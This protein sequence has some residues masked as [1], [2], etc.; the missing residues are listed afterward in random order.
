MPTS[1]HFQHCAEFEKYLAATGVVK[2]PDDYVWW[3]N[4]ISKWLGRRIGPSELSEEKDVQRLLAEVRALDATSPS[5]RL[6]TNAGSANN[7][8][9]ILRKYAKMVQSGYLA[10]ATNPTATP[11]VTA[12]LAALE[13][14]LYAHLLETYELAGRQT[15]YWG[16]RF[17]IAL[18]K[19]GASVTAKRMMK[20]SRKMVATPGLQTLIDAGR[21]DLSVEAAVLLPQFQSLFTPAEL[22]EARRRLDNLP[23]YVKRRPVPPESNFPDEIA[24]DADFTEGGKRQVTVNAYERNPAA[25]DACLAKHGRRCSVC[26]MSFLE[27][28]GE[29]GKNFIHVH[30]KKPLAAR[31]GEYKV[32]PTT[33]LSPV[34]PNCHAMLHTQNPPL[35][36]DELKSILDRHQANKSS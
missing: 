27:R 5:D 20:P 12:D 9:S 29:I 11:V 23:A 28:Y 3:M 15:G 6:L 33:D 22:A 18:K 13:K 16:K 25:R 17:L 21:T 8:Q 36:I 4:A 26:D 24:P 1:A 14:K 19:H 30:H 10:S 35:G 32:N 2:T 31:R 34:C 7:L